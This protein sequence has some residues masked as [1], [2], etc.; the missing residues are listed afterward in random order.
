MKDNKEGFYR[1]IEVT[2]DGDEPHVIITRVIPEK[3][4]SVTRRVQFYFEKV[5]K[6]SLDK[7]LNKDHD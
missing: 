2:M 6:E 4:P 5:V 7:I 3:E 1:D